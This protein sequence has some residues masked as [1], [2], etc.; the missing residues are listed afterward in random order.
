VLLATCCVYRAADILRYLLSPRQRRGNIQSS[1]NTSVRLSCRSKRDPHHTCRDEH[2]WPAQVRICCRAYKILREE[3]GFDPQDIIFDP[4]ILTIGTGLA[5]HNNYAVD[6]IRC[7]L[8][9]PPFAVPHLYKTCAL[10]WHSP[11]G[12]QG[13]VWASH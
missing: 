9:N 6:F 5:E 12:S 13:W 4:N 10:H 8:R 11:E 1:L 3:I 2:R 7:A